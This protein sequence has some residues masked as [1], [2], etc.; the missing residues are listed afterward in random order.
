MKNL[1]T[2]RVVLPNTD[3]P[4]NNKPPRYV[5]MPQRHLPRR[6]SQQPSAP[7]HNPVNE[8]HWRMSIF[9][10]FPDKIAPPP[11]PINNQP[12]VWG[13]DARRSSMH[14]C[15]LSR[16]PPPPPSMPMGTTVYGGKGSK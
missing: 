9:T 2:N 3:I 10:C 4:R 15:K 5:E 8:P 16:P 14:F 11:K 13:I 6:S 7:L 1:P 12:C